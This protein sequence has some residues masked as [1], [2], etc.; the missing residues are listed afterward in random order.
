MTSTFHLLLVLSLHGPAVHPDTAG[1]DHWVQLEDGGHGDRGVF[2]EEV[3]GS[4]DD[5]VEAA[6]GG[7]H[8]SHRVHAVADPELHLA[9]PS[10][11]GDAVATHS[12]RGP[13]AA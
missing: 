13:P 11:R 6:S 2:A 9:P 3:E 8:L 5:R 7:A 12:A 4:K 1:A 10:V